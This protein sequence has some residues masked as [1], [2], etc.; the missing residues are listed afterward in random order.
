MTEKGEKLFKKLLPLRKL[1]PRGK[2]F[3]PGGWPLWRRAGQRGRP[4][5]FPARRW[6]GQ[7]RG[8]AAVI[9]NQAM[10]EGMKRV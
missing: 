10:T 7:P 8:G 2:W 6:S 5:M 9:K 3:F 4:A 1:L